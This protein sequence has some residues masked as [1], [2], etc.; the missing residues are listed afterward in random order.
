MKFV[1]TGNYANGAQDA[2]LRYTV[3]A[4]GSTSSNIPEN[5]RSRTLMYQPGGIGEKRPVVFVSLGRT[6]DHEASHVHKGYIPNAGMK[7]QKSI[8]VSCLNNDASRMFAM[9]TTMY[10]KGPLKMQVTNGTYVQLSS[11]TISD[12]ESK[13]ASYTYL[14]FTDTLRRRPT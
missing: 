10:D 8:S 1:A 2:F 9:L 11:R 14:L 6:A 13:P 4:Y 3:E 7:A 12:T 5:H